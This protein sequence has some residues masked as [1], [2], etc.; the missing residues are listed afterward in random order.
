VDEVC[1]EIR[2]GYLALVEG[3]AFYRRWWHDGGAVFALP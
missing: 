1:E 2:Q 3:T